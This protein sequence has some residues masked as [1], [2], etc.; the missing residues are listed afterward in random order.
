M[1]HPSLGQT[2]AV[3]ND[4]HSRLNRTRVATVITVTSPE[5]IIKTLNSAARNG[6]AVAIAG[7][8]HAMGG[9]QFGAGTVLL[10]MRGLNRILELDAERGILRVEA[11][12]EW[13][14]LMLG[15]HVR[16]R[17][18][19]RQWGVAQKQTGADRLSIGGAVAANIHGRGL[20][21]KPFIQDIVAL[22]AID[23]D[24]HLISC[25]R[26]QNPALFRLIVGG[27]G[28]FG[29]VIRVTLRLAPRQKLERVVQLLGI[30]EL[31]DAFEEHIA[32]GCLYGDFQFATAPDSA[33]FLRTGV[34]SCYKPVANDKPIPSGQL[35]LSKA[36]WR[37]LLY[38][39]HADKQAAFRHFA[40]FYLASSGQL[41]WSDTHQ[42]S[43]Y[44]D[45]Y[46]TDLDQE[47]GA[48][49]AATEI[50]TEL[51][52]PRARLSAFMEAVRKDFRHHAVDLIYGT[53]RLIE[54]DDESFLAWA[55]E[56]YACVIFNLHTEHTPQGVEKSRA[57]LGRLID[58]AIINQGS[59]FLTYHRFA[60]PEQVLACYPQFP[61]F[62]AAKRRYDPQQRFQSDWHRHYAALL[63][64][65][66]R[67]RSAG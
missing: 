55:K 19:T 28:L 56:P 37:R 52:V 13:P 18:R 41:Y 48:S 42:L 17:G 57:A 66:I 29:V 24:G 39:A 59:Y 47:L 36:D 46:H 21:M 15:C 51:Y 60:S 3:V 25:S 27:Y 54:R 62:L 23:A 26:R 32:E 9:Q 58:L 10:D 4:V 6:K 64:Q 20:R 16:Q 22:E 2:G 7:G 34:F 35:R 1:P 63:D 65:P 44:L 38:L 43:L 14:E 12:I 45:D 40:D 61:D 53:I 30:D 11:G 50:I 67:L 49:V 31:M 8:R 33:D 5:D